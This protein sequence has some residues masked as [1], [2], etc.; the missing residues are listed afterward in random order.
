LGALLKCTGDTGLLVNS[1]RAFVAVIVAGKNE[2]DA[3]VVED[4]F[5]LE[6]DV[7]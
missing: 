1:A 6:L 4:G 2:I 5:Q 7:L 3:V